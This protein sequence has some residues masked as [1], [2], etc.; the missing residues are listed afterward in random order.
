MARGKI[1]KENP[2][3]ALDKVPAMMYS[4]SM[5]TTRKKLIVV[6][7]NEMEHRRLKRLAKRMGRTMSDTV[8]V[9]VKAAFRTEA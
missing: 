2:R 7:A 1:I 5:N 3:I 8:R 9:L 6:R 4:H